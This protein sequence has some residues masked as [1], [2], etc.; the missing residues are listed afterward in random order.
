MHFTLY[1]LPFVFRIVSEAM[2]L[3]ERRRSINN[4]NVYMYTF[5]LEPSIAVFSNDSPPR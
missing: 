4:Y 2:Y 3:F 1:I 5:R